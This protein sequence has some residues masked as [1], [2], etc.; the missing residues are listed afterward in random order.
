MYTRTYKKIINIIYDLMM[1]H[2]KP[3]H[4]LDLFGGSSICSLYFHINNIEVTYNDILRFNSIN[5]NGLLDIDLNN[6]PDEEEIKNIFVKNSNSCYTTFIHDTFKDIYYTD[7]DDFGILYGAF[8]IMP[9]NTKDIFLS[10]DYKESFKDR[11]INPIIA[12]TNTPSKTV[13]SA[14]LRE[15]IHRELSNDIFR[16]DNGVEIIGNCEIHCAIVLLDRASLGNN[17]NLTIE[18]A[19]FIHSSWEN[20]EITDEQVNSIIVKVYD[21]IIESRIKK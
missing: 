15:I 16:K 8:V 3:I 9:E 6:I 18:L 20:L 2:F 10:F 17:F 12:N 11:K 5:A 21:M 19:Q 13:T 1:T 4:I 7:E 14:I